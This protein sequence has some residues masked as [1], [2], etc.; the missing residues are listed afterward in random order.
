[1][2]KLI[3]YLK[4]YKLQAILGPL[5]KLLEASFELMIPLIVAEIIDVGIK[6]GDS[7]FIIEMVLLIILL[8]VVGF[9]CSITAQYFSA[10]AAVGFSTILRS[11]TFKKIQSLSFNEYDELGT[12]TLITR[13]TN[14]IN[15]IQNGVN[16]TLRLFLR[17]PFIVFGSMIMAFTVDVQSAMIFVVTIPVLAVIVFLIL[18]Y[19]MPLYKKVQTNVDDV[20]CKTREN[21]TGVRVIRAFSKE[22]D[23]N[24]DF[25]ILNER[26][27]D[28]QNFVSR[29]SN[30]MNPLTY[31]IINISIIVLLSTTSVKVNNNTLTQGEVIALYN[32]MSQILVELIKLA[33]LIISISKAF[34]CANRVSSILQ[35]NSTLK[36]SDLTDVYSRNYIEF[37]NVYFRYKN[38][39]E[40]ALSNISFSVN[41][42][43]TVGIIG[44]TGSGKSTLVN[45]I[46]HFY[47]ISNGYISFKGKSI[48]NID[49]TELRDKIGIATQK[50]VLFKGTIRSNLLLGNPNATDDEMIEA[51]RL[52]SGLEIL[53]GKEN[54][55]DSVVEQNG[56]NFSGGQK[57]RLNIA[58]ALIKKPE[59]LILDDSQSA[60]DYATDSVI[61]TN[62]KKLSYKPTVFIVSQRTSSIKHADKIIVLD[63]GKMI[64]YGTHEE[65]LNKCS[66]YSEI[67]YSQYKKENQ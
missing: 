22:E 23:E 31:A 24:R 16:L 34:A 41:K 63:D 67:H 43:E 33:N 35:M 28:N 56:R 45:L 50:S 57:Q 21:L 14:D 1:M 39:N 40:Y 6:N 11:E 8:G 38:V 26:L 17:S 18:L 29:I 60:L 37:K 27:K 52:A 49:Q 5:F 32:Y 48:T 58:R 3:V 53:K 47:D 54:G 15:Q 61:R 12:S 19:T 9:I 4:K 42:G 20:V 44:A 10:K 51:L 36:D 55:L 59:V 30:L 13:I 66:I 7:G 64:G 62:L 65:L 25:V 46:P 2:K